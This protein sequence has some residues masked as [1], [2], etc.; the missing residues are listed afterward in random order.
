MGDQKV[1]SAADGDRRRNFMRLLLNDL[2]ALEQM[3]SDGMIERDVRRIGAEQELFL[4]DPNWRPASA[5][6]EVLDAID[7]PAFTTE[8][9]QFN[10]ELNLDPLTFGGSCLG[11]LERALDEKLARLDEVTEGMGLRVVLSGI[12]PTL[13]QS[14][15]TLDNMTPRPRYRALNDAMSSLRGG[16]YEFHIRGLHELLLKHDS[17]MLEACNASF[18]VHFQ[19]GVDESVDLYNIAQVVAAPV[20][21]A[22]CNSPVLFGRQLWRETRIALFQQAVDTRSSMDF[23]RE[24]SPRVTFGNDW[25]HSSLVELFQEDVTRFRA[26]VLGD[27]SDDSLEQLS[28]G[29]VPKLRALG[30]HNGTVYRW[31]RACYGLT[32]GKP[33]LRLENRVL[34]AGPTVADEVANAAFWFGTISGLFNKYRDITQLISF[35]DAKLNFTAGARLG[36]GA[37]LNWLQGETLPAATV[38]CDRLLPLAQEGLAQAGIDSA[39]IERY[40]AIVERRV[41]SHRTGAQWV[42]GSLAGMRGQGTTGE[43]MTALTAA[44]WARSRER[45]PVSEWAP[46]RLEESGGWKHNFIKVEQYMSTDLFTVGADESL[47]LVASLMEWKR[48]RY[49]P[50]EDHQHKLVGL[51]T[52][53]ALIKLIGRGLDS[54][55]VPVTEVMI[56]HPHTIEPE[57]S[58]LAAIAMMRDKRIGCLPVVKGERLVGVITERDLMNVAAELLKEQLEE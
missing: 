25:V 18:Q 36:L 7:D 34:P 39:D 3:M 21:A 37:Q 58:T 26:L 57:A 19:I 40:L 22:A 10:L 56:T 12:L 44:M 28:R 6:T 41:S 20:L 5:A 15:L 14:D 47:D 1:V 30:L 24:R 45:N 17:V 54:A 33:H 43:Q 8:L 51:V 13:R 35:E 2:R 53:R 49:V 48:I 11:D 32:D 29:E 42:V 55:Q 31:N 52:Y 16:A 9:G 46:A 23:L 27:V 4:C 38:I 50:V